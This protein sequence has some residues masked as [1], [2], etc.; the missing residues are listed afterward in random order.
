MRTKA[1]YNGYEFGWAAALAYAAGTKADRRR[2]RAYLS[3]T[4]ENYGQFVEGYV[5]G[6]ADR[7]EQRIAAIRAGLAPRT[8]SPAKLGYLVNR[9]G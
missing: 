1:F 5:R 4:A 2:V 3:R 6:F 8:I 7:A 9:M